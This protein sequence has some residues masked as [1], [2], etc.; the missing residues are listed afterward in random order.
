M[1][2]DLNTILLICSNVIGGL[3]LMMFNDLKAEG[4][5]TRQKFEAHV[6]DHLARKFCA[7]HLEIVGF[8]EAGRPAN[9]H[10]VPK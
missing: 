3:L 8:N 6:Q 4:K 7:P 1:H 9:F 5:E 2:F 10:L